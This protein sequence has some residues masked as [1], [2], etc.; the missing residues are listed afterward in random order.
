MRNLVSIQRVSNLQA[1]EGKDLIEQATVLGWNLIVKKGEFK[2]GDLAVYCEIDS[3]LPVQEE[4]EFLRKKC[5]NEK[6]NGF[7]IKTLK[8]SGV[9]SQGIL[10]PLSLLEADWVKD[11]NKIKI[12]EDE[13]ITENILVQKYEEDESNKVIEYKHQKSKLVKYLCKFKFFRQFFVKQNTGSSKFPSWIEK[14]DETRVQS[15][16]ETLKPYEGIKCYASVKMDGQS[17]TSAFYKN[18]LW[19]CS[20][21]KSYKGNGDSNFEKIAKKYN[22]QVFLKKM[23]KEF[24]RN[25]A[26]QGEICGPNIQKNKYYLN[27]LKLFIFSFYDIDNHKYCNYEDFKKFFE[28]LHNQN[29]IFETVPILSNDYELKVDIDHLLSIAKGNSIKYPAT[30]EGIVIR[31]LDGKPENLPKI[32]SH[33]S[34]KVINND[35]LIEHGL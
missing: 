12:R 7:R 33:F 3:I 32:G 6:L 8:M 31:S 21:N 2:I 20:R 16:L 14:T 34:F 23:N 30:R 35:F 10:F 5:F 27:E 26:I 1:I 29:S 15:I 9:I 11:K 22:L 19:I 18:R 28:F 25:I 24:H 17:F 13:D 4:F